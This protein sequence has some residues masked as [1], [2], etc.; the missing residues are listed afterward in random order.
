M[1]YLRTDDY[2]DEK[3][4]KSMKGNFDIATCNDPYLKVKALRT[5]EQQFDININSGVVNGDDGPI[6]LDDSLFKLARATFK[7]KQPTN[8]QGLLKFYI[9]AIKH[10][11]SPDIVEAKQI[12]HGEN[13]KKY[14]YKLNIQLVLE[15]LELNSLKNCR[16]ADVKARYRTIYF[17]KHGT[18]DDTDDSD[19]DVD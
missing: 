19:S 12:S 14:F 1:R 8:R 2:I 18:A 9:A 7:Q 10:H 11:V 15:H 16:L 17:V 3:L 4:E 5:I 6:E 13:R